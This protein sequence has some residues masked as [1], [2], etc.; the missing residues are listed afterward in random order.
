M[1]RRLIGWR[2]RWDR[3]EF[4]KNEWNSDWTEVT[5]LV[6]ACVWARRARTSSRYRNIRLMRVYRRKR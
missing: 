4:G 6:E 1:T 5:G 3:C 2:V